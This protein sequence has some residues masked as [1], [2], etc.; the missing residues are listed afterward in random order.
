[1]NHES[2]NKHSSIK[3]NENIYLLADNLL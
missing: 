1:M 2:I 3:K